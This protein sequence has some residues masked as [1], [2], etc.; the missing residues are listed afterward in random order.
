MTEKVK[1]NKADKKNINK[2]AVAEKIKAGAWLLETAFRVT[3][4]VAAINVTGYIATAVAVYALLTA[5]LI[6]ISHF[7]AAHTK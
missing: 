1:T 4:G 3:V 6:V 2:Q 7:G 5:A